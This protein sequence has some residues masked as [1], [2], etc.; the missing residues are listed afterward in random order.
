VIGDSKA[1]DGVVVF[2]DLRASAGNSP[3]GDRL[4]PT[5]VT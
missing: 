5:A 1:A 2:K 4:W 3:T